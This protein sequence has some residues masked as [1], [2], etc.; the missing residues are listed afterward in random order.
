VAVPVS[1][2]PS[3]TWKP[4]TGTSRTAVQKDILCL[5][6][7]VGYLTS[8][9]AYFNRSDVGVY[10]HFVVGGPWGTD[11]GKGLDG[12]VWQLADTDY[13]AAANLNGN[14]RIISVETADNAARPIQPWTPAQCEALSQL[15]A[16]ANRLDGSPLVAIPDSKPGRRGIAWH[17]LGCDPYRV[18]GGELWSSSPGKDCPTQARIDQIPGLIARARAIVSG[19]PEEDVMTDAQMAELKAYINERIRTY[20][21]YAVSAISGLS[22]NSVFAVKG[23]LRD[24]LANA[25]DEAALADLKAEVDALQASVDKLL[26]A[27]PD[28]TRA[29]AGVPS[30]QARSDA[31]A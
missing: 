12:V 25:D 17:R 2:Y 14:Y 3:A 24:R 11:A 27:P 26:P 16:D 21:S 4:I 15:M 10:S 23:D 31:E 29:S 1:R 7:A 30:G 6:T 13:R 8:T 20:V 28:P 18:D 22:S 19:Q 9:W 5:H